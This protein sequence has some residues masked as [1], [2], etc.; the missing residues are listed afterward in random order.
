MYTCA[1]DCVVSLGT[2]LTDAC[3]LL[4]GRCELIPG[5]LQ[6]YQVITARVPI[7]YMLYIL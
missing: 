4:N 6:K 1:Q 3:K 5:C 2:G 7:L